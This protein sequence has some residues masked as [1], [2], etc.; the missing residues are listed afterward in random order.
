MTLNVA[1]DIAS[2]I[3]SGM[4]SNNHRQLSNSTVK[5]IVPVVD[6]DFDIA[7]PL[8]SGYEDMAFVHTNLQTRCKH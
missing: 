1:S 7:I 6:D 4:K 3:A 8:N 5:K 2:D